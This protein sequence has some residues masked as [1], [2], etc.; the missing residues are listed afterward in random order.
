MLSI[1]CKFAR[2]LS[3]YSKDISY[4]S[5]WKMTPWERKPLLT[6]GGRWHS[7]REAWSTTDNITRTQEDWQTGSKAR[8]TGA[9]AQKLKFL[10]KGKVEYDLPT[11][12]RG[13]MKEYPRSP[14]TKSST[15]VSK[16]SP[17]LSTCAAVFTAASLIL[18]TTQMSIH[19]RMDKLGYA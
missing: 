4:L 5:N 17:A 15:P 3:K 19:S 9:E 18:E 10:R 8:T 16:G 7:S 12:I 14:G 13:R 2:E 1:L 6:T 11:R